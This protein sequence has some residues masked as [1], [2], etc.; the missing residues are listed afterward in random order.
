MNSAMYNGQDLM[1]VG[2]IIIMGHESLYMC[3][4]VCERES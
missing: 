1:H 4:C 3:V 2:L